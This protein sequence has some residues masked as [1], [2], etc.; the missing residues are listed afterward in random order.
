MIFGCG[1]FDGRG[2]DGRVCRMI[3]EG[4][5]SVFFPKR[6]YERK[7]RTIGRRMILEGGLSVLFS[8][9]FSPSS[10]WH[11]S[12]NDDDPDNGYL[13]HLINVIG[14]TFLHS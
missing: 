14:V 3:L 9:K 7:E 5:L 4:E 8:K 2:N 13:C 10:F 12:F 11:P 6:K 1:G